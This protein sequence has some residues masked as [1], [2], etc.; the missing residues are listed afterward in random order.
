[1]ILLA[2][3]SPF[4]RSPVPSEP[5]ARR[6]TARGPG[7][8]YE[9]GQLSRPIHENGR[10]LVMREGST[11]RLGPPM[12]EAELEALPLPWA[13]SDWKSTGPEPRT[14]ASSVLICYDSI[15]SAVCIAF[16]VEV[17]WQD[18]VRYRDSARS[19]DT[20][21]R[22]GPDYDL[23]CPSCGDCCVGKTYARGARGTYR[24]SYVAYCVRRILC[25][26]CGVVGDLES[27]TTLD[28]RL[29]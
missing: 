14:A 21:D 22:E 29:W 1:M 28:C 7:I 27:G 10:A 20:A 26:H 12:G 24:N 16:D 15:W 3:G 2:A 5:R 23:V 25:N 13:R 6:S 18:V 8:G 11:A 9:T 17:I 19:W 4:R